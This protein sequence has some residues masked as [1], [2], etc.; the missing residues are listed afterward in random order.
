MVDRSTIGGFAAGIVLGLVLGAA[1]MG[2]VSVAPGS[3]GT[4]STPRY[5]YGTSGGCFD[6]ANPNSGWVHVV[7]N[8][9]TWATTVNATVV[10]DPGTVVD[11]TVRERPSGRT[12]IALQTSTETTDA[13]REEC[14]SATTLTIGAAVATPELVV[15]MNG[16]TVR[17]I[18]QD[19][20]TPNLY[21]LPNPINATG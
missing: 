18:S 3:D 13:A 12:E 8:G 15:T 2:T 20:T 11:V 1:L 6:G 14:L 19:E 5:S 4:T 21:P 10:H 16:D 9:E 17:T 7:A